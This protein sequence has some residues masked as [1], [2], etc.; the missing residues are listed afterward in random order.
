MS[1]THAFRYTHNLTHKMPPSEAEDREN[2]EFWYQKRES[3]EK[4]GKAKGGS[5][6]E[7]EVVLKVTVVPCTPTLHGSSHEALWSIT[8]D[9][10]SASHGRSHPHGNTQLKGCVPQL[11]DMHTSSDLKPSDQMNLSGFE[12]IHDKRWAYCCRHADEHELQI[13]PHQLY[14]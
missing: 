7:G 3:W 1:H 4:G 12:Y 11:S 14:W 5:G 2:F 9:L 6:G 8:I 13:L 10:P